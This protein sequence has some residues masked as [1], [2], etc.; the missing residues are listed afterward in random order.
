MGLLA[1][2][3]NSINGFEGIIYL[4]N[5]QGQRNAIPY[6]FF[7]LIPRCQYWFVD[8]NYPRKVINLN[9]FILK[10]PYWVSSIIKFI[11][12]ISNERLISEHKL[13]LFLF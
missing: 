2:G 1:C 5:S 11:I 13:T 7:N 3:R 6:Q 9:L 10:L 8:L 12:L 4:R